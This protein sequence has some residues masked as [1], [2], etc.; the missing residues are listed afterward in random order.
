MEFGIIGFVL[1]ITAVI[2]PWV[3]VVRIS[4]LKRELEELREVVR[5]LTQSL[6]RERGHEEQPPT[7]KPA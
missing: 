2:V 4:S 5:K 7:I 3:N 6:Q 1:F